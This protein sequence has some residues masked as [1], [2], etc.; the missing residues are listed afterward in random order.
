MKRKIIAGSILAVFLMMT[1]SIVS[2]VGSETSTAETKES[3][4]YRIRT[5]RA[6]SERI[7]NIIENI[8]VNFIGGNR[9]FVVPFEWI[10]RAYANRINRFDTGLVTCAS[11]NAK[12]CECPTQFP[13]QVMTCGL[14]CSLTIRPRCPD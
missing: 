6:I 8:Y 5:N 2:V 9:L 4:L 14:Q 11:W 10:N 7:G 1:I 12:Y 3:P 13:Y